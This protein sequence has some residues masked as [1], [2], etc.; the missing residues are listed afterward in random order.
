MPKPTARRAQTDTSPTS[1]IT[2]SSAPSAT[3][4]QQASH[5]PDLLAKMHPGKF[6]QTSWTIGNSGDLVPGRAKESPLVSLA[7][8]VIPSLLVAAVLYGMMHIG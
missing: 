5:D 1:S 8:V 6:G 3:E 4:V 2:H 7:W